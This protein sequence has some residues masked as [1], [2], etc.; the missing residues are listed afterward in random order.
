MKDISEVPTDG[1]TIVGV[2]NGFESLVLNKAKALPS[3]E[4]LRECFHYDD[5]TGNLYW[6][7][8]PEGHFKDGKRCSSSQ[9]C[10]SWNSKNAGKSAGSCRKDGYLHNRLDGSRY[11]THRLIWKMTK[12]RDPRHIDHINGSKSD[13]RIDN[14]RCVLQEDNNKNARRRKDN[15]S[16]NTG[17]YFSKGFWFAQLGC[18]RIGRFKDKIDATY[19][20]YWA[21]KDAGYHEN[22][23]RVVA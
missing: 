18:V 16:G 17:V 12:G 9:L 15:T 1:T 21:E 10:K 8:R 2:Y 6:K 22:H 3:Q 23:G 11:L 5:G 20:R 4:Y 7:Q 13:N 19:A 14:L